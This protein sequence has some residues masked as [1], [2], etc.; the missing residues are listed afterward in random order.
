MQTCGFKNIKLVPKSNSK[1]IIK[2]W[3]FGDHVE[4]YVASYLIEAIKQ[5]TS[6]ARCG[7]EEAIAK[8]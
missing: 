2:S 4:D 8:S 1:D 5:F 3:N 7:R 6:T